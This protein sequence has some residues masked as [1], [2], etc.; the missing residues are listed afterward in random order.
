MSRVLL[1]SANTTLEPYPVFPLGMALVAGALAARGHEVRQFDFLAAG[2][3]TARLV[4]EIEEFSPACVGLS[5][6]NIDN[7]DS[8]AAGLAWY[9][10]EARDLAAAVRGATAAP[11]L[12]GGAGFT[13]MPEEILAYL[14]GDHGV[15]GEGEE[16]ACA[17]VEALERGETPPRIL[18]AKDDGH[19]IARPAPPL[20]ERRWVE[21]YL[22][23][24]GLVNLQTKRGCPH[25]CSYCT[26]PVIEGNCFRARDPGAVAEELL[27]LKADFGV[28][29]VFFTDS[30]FNDEG[31]HHLQVAEELVRREVGIRWAAI[32]RPQRARSAELELL[33]RSGLY[34]MELGTDASTDATLAGLGKGFT[35]GEVLAFNEAAVAAEIPAAHFVMFG[36][37]GETE[38]TVREGLENLGRLDR[39]VI[40]AYS[41][42]R[43]LPGTGLHR[44]AVGEG[45][46]APGDSLLRPAYYFAPGVDPGAMNAQIERAFRGRRERIFPPEEGRLRMKVM[47]RFGYRGL[48]WD[49]L[50]RFAA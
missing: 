1:V 39:S 47:R 32:F 23:E 8:T 40:F 30:V 19:G 7:V 34:A 38:T 37:P 15:A 20:L 13:I 22:R 36:G 5:L 10:D 46:L 16:L 43:I 24:T 28:E 3:D 11:L 35:F 25:R 26:Y 44:R 49:T 4:R 21:Y 33:K 45:L 14:G 27:R 12:L 42:I 50:I 17:L 2:R 41:G 31:G 6:R 29:R 18:R 9:L 48:L